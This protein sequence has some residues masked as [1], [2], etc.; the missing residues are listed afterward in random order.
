MIA[1]ATDKEGGEFTLHSLPELIN[2]EAI[3]VLGRDKIIVLK[4]GYIWDGVLGKYR[5]TI[6]EN[7]K[8]YDE[9]MEREWEQP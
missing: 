8:Y 4:N 7:K 9:L 2:K 6:E 3:R 1:F 5:G